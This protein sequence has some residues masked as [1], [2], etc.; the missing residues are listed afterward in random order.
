MA[1]DVLVKTK[2]MTKGLEGEVVPQIKKPDSKV[3]LF[4]GS[5]KKITGDKIDPH[6]VSAD[7][8]GFEEGGIK[9]TWATSDIHQAARYAGESGHIYEVHEKPDDLDTGFSKYSHDNA[10]NEGGPL[11]IKQE[12]GRPGLNLARLKH[13]SMGHDESR[14]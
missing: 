5:P 1:Q 3:R 2:K 8:L 12:V 11:T 4:H 10:F 7:R 6:Y 13:F 9:G 14:K